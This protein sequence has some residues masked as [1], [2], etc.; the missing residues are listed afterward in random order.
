MRKII[1]IRAFDAEFDLAIKTLSESERITKDTLR[2]YAN[3]AI[4][5]VHQ[6]GQCAYLNKLSSA[7]T[8]VNRKVWLA[9]AKHFAGFH[10]DNDQL[11]FDKKSKKRYAQAVKDW[12]VFREDPHNNIWTWAER[13]IQ[14]EVKPYTV[15]KLQKS[16]SS[17]WKAAHSANIKNVEVIRALMSVKGAD[18]QP[19]FSMDDVAE[20]L[21]MVQDEKLVRVDAPDAMI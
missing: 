15:D 9:F 19:V 17:A 16:M 3:L 2:L 12:D 7:L 6:T 8:P 11:M 13:N 20:A 10:Y 18:G 4:D 21:Q 1:D 14:V 5:A